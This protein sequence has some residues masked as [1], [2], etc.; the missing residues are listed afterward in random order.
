M[1]DHSYHSAYA[2]YSKS[3][4]TRL[5]WNYE[6]FDQT[7]NTLVSVVSVLNILS[8]K[9]AKCTL[10]SLWTFLNFIQERP[11]VPYGWLSLTIDT[12]NQ[13]NL[14]NQ[15]N[16]YNDLISVQYSEYSYWLY[17]ERWW[18][19]TSYAQNLAC[20]GDS[21]DSSIRLCGS[22]V[23]CLYWDHMMYMMHAY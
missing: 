20:K 6:L 2:M 9:C 13:V 12:M 15:G 8:R 1:T 18:A 14:V 23:A 17:S 11:H 21:S 4:L 5:A 3:N 22:L 10:S 7:W 16:D 19:S